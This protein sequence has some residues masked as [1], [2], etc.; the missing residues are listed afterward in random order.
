M[1]KEHK[2]KMEIDSCIAADDADDESDISSLLSQKSSSNNSQSKEEIAWQEHKKQEAQKKAAI[3]NLFK[4][5]EPQLLKSDWEM[6]KALSAPPPPTTKKRKAI[7]KKKKDSSDDEEEE[8][9]KP[10]KKQNKP[11]S[12]KAAAVDNG[13]PQAIIQLFDETKKHVTPKLLKYIETKFQD[14]ISEEFDDSLLMHSTKNFCEMWR[15]VDDFSTAA[16]IFSDAFI[17]EYGE[18]KLTGATAREQGD[19]FA[20]SH[21]NNA[22]MM[23]CM[24]NPDG[25]AILRKRLQETR[26]L[27]LA[28]RKQKKT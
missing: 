23:F 13:D 11:K 3:A 7:E 20:D 27:L 26:A 2:I 12:K 28:K 5:Q 1:A 19:R 16:H 9:K 8:T 25:A 15:Q 21:L 6:S 24:F 10:K 18:V 4:K 22:I 14:I 17:A